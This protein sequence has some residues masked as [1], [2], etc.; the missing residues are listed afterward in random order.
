MST[1]DSMIT[2]A[3]R[4]LSVAR[5]V[6]ILTGAGISAESG[7][8]TF[9][10]TMEGL[11][12][13][14]DPA[15]LA[16]PEAFA[17]DPELVTRWY[18]WRRLGCLAA[19]PN[20]GHLALA[21]MEANLTERGGSCALFT[22]NVDRLHRRAGSQNIIELHGSIIQWRCTLTHKLT[23]PP[24]VAF[25][26]YPPPSP[27]AESGL[28]R[29]N[30]VWFGESLPE[31]ALHAAMTVIP[32]CDL[33]FT[34]GTSAVVY[35]AAG[36]VKLASQNGAFTIEVNRDETPASFGVDISLRGSAGEILPEIVK[37]AFS[38]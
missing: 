23:D 38:L 37:R 26:N 24:A 17:R 35:P 27:F 30:V 1:R 14:F 13:D 34:I 29:P 2:F 25:E 15:T 5:R 4:R 18:D 19:E 9:R 20:A 8:R 7:I 11:W 36:F 22:Q 6:C 28:L 16:T 3:A 33:F 32:D 10:D 12:K 31:D 21:Q